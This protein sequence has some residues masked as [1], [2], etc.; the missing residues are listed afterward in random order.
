MTS[1]HQRKE[2]VHLE[3]AF[4]NSFRVVVPGTVERLK[5]HAHQLNST[6]DREP[7]INLILSG[8]GAII[9]F[10][11]LL[12]TDVSAF[13]L[14]YNKQIYCILGHGNHD[15]LTSNKRFVQ[16]IGNELVARG[17]VDPA[18]L[19]NINTQC[20]RL[21]YYDHETALLVRS[22]KKIPLDGA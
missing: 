15:V 5:E 3:G 13:A 20:I 17:L 2:I 22:Q 21:P 6:M 14:I 11:R 8:E 1:L 4:I 10:K 19:P 16:D 12:D 7:Y 9:C 18:T